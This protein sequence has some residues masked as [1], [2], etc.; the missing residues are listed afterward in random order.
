[1]PVY[2]L[3]LSAS[4]RNKNIFPQSLGRMIIPK[5]TGAWESKYLAGLPLQWRRSRKKGGENGFTFVS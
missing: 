2:S 1:M 4:I 3:L 5:Y